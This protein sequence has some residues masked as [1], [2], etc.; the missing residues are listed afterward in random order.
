MKGDLGRPVRGRL[1]TLVFV[2]GSGVLTLLTPDLTFAAEVLGRKPV[3]RGAI[4][5]GLG[6]TGA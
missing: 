6:L 4:G 1:L 3:G 2:L 5:L